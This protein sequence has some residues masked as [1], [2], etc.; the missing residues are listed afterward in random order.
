MMF[1]VDLQGEM[2]FEKLNLSEERPD[3][4][5][6]PLLGP[7]LRK[8]RLGDQDELL[9]EQANRLAIYFLNKDKHWDLDNYLRDKW[10]SPFDWLRTAW[11]L[12]SL[13]TGY[14]DTYRNE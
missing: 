12:I 8:N 2:T 11:Y 5:S 7:L 13:K 4:L 14:A 3:L 9:A 6:N 1:H 10:L